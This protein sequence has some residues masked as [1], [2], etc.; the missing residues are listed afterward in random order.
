MRNI[1]LHVQQEYGKKM[2][3]SFKMGINREKNGQFLQL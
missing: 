3:K 1:H 2:L